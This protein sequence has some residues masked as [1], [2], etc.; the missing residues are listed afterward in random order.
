MIAA[1]TGP[2]TPPRAIA[3]PKIKILAQNPAAGGTPASDTMNSDIPTARNGATPGDPGEV[4]R[5]GASG[6]AC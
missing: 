2:S 1:S 6:F 4:A 3:A 5:S